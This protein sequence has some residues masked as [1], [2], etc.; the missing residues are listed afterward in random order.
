MRVQLCAILAVAH[1]G[2]NGGSPRDAL[3]ADSTRDADPSTTIVP[4]AA[5][6]IGP[7]LPA[8]RQDEDPAIV[9]GAHGGLVALWYSNRGTAMAGPLDKQIYA[10]HSTDGTIWSTPVPVSRATA[11]TD[12]SFAPSVTQGPN[13]S[14]LAAWWNVHLLPDGC[15]PMVNCT[16]T[17][18]TVLAS[19]SQ[20]TVQWT[21]PEQVLTGAGDWLPSIAY[22]PAAARTLVYFAATARSSDGSVDLAQTTSRLFVAIKTGASWSSAIPLTGV[23]ASNTHQSYPFVVRTAAGSYRMTWT[24]FSAM[25][26]AGGPLDVLS[27][28]TTETMVATSSDG[29]A[30]TNVRVV[31]EATGTFVDV[32]PTLHANHAGSAWSVMWETTDGAVSGHTVELPFE[33]AYPKDRALRPELAGYTPRAIATATPGVFWGVWVDGSE[34]TQRVRSRFF[35]K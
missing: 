1:C 4:G 16:G 35:T 34:P 19:T 6:L 17:R 12:W 29:I 8:G 2:G 9:V 18:N 5:F 21:P 13:G 25:G 3:V 20:D 31:S 11:G 24:R 33:G 15:T 10:T 7:D 26:I 22:D 30:W 27:T 23:D 28:P 32:F 14:V